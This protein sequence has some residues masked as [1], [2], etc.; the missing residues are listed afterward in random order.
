MASPSDSA[1][2]VVIL[3]ARAEAALIDLKKTCSINIVML[4]IDFNAQVE[5]LSRGKSLRWSMETNWSQ[6]R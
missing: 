1:G 2:T 3:R 6:V 5:N 4:A